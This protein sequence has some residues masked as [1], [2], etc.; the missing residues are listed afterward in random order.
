MARRFS[1]PY[2]SEPVSSLATWARNLAIFS[3]I[4][5]VVSIL[6]VRFGFLEMKPALATFFGALAV[7]GLSILVGLAAFAM[8]VLNSQG[9]FFAAALGPAVLNVGMIVV[10]LALAGHVDPPILSL[11]FGVL[12]GA[13][14]AL[15]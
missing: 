12:A 5:V 4:A 9:R 10:V 8:G 3:I 11:A 13:A 7:A 2:Q 14:A 6:I 1:A 15:G